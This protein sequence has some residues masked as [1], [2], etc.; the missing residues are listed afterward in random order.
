LDGNCSRRKRGEVHRD[1]LD[2]DL[3]AV[4]SFTQA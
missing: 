4:L 3:A 1:Q 2:V